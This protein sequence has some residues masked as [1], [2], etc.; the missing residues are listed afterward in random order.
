MNEG[1]NADTAFNSS[2]V[3]VYA[4]DKMNSTLN[5][6]LKKEVKGNDNLYIF[7]YQFQCILEKEITVISHGQ[8][9][10]YN[11]WLIRRSM[12]KWKNEATLIGN[13]KWFVF[14]TSNLGYDYVNWFPSSTAGLLYVT[15]PEVVMIVTRLK[16]MTFSDAL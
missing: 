4:V 8:E 15:W 12:W 16:V 1:I 5:S 7:Y 9:E 6:P 11:L 10:N 3:E 14:P 2:D 13:K